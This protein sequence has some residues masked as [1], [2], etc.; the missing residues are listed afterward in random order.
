VNPYDEIPY[1]S[2]VYTQSHPETLAL[3]ALTR[4]LRA[5]P[6]DRC[7]VLE[8][9]CNDGTNLLAIAA[10]FPDVEAVGVDL[11]GLP[12]AA[13]SAIAADARLGNVRLL[14]GDASRPD[15]AWGTFDY[16][17]AHGL[18]SWVPAAVRDGI[19]A[20]I[21]QVLR[22]DGVAFVSYSAYPGAYARRM[23]REM[24]LL[25][26]E[27]APT[28]AERAQRSVEMLHAV[29]AAR[30]AREAPWDAWLRNEIERRLEVPISVLEHDDLAEVNDPVW[31]HE[32]VRHSA[33][34]GLR[35]LAE[36]EW[37][38]NSDLAFPE[39]LQRALRTVEDPLGREQVRDLLKVRR[40]RQTLL[41]H[42]HAE[43]GP[44]RLEGVGRL[45]ASSVVRTDA[46]AP[47]LA[48]AAVESFQGRR[49]G[50]V[51]TDSRIVRAALRTLTE[52][53]P[54]RM[55]VSDL[56][57]EAVSRVTAACGG[58]LPPGDGPE[59]F[60]E[61]LPALH[62]AG[63]VG[64]H[65]TAPDAPATPGPRPTANALARAMAA[66]GP[67]AVS[68]LQELVRLEDPRARRLI[69]LL[70]GTRDRAEILAL[71]RRAE[72]PPNAPPPGAP[73]LSEHLLEVSLQ[74]LAQQGFLT[75]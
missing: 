52:R 69:P 70:D 41:V 55:R 15:P 19:L 65:L 36:A 59:S 47:S 49:G 24:M 46:E 57:A 23:F 74:N 45:F 38:E 50:R 5:A 12:V 4:G 58:S 31:F 6:P 28:V 51:Q 34:H 48:V 11:A 60:L 42:S 13:G 30:G 61:V 2:H 14:V 32:F 43:P 63:N 72:E 33:S 37:A 3:A 16:V 44:V 62:D 40:F 66:R 54:R 73:P 71:L 8:L 7:R 27:G 22:P 18:Y 10:A 25:Y 39:G 9:G 56:T 67:H 35:Y 26:S 29:A 75:A 68:L 64:L 20:T 53:W 1:P 17:I 21:R